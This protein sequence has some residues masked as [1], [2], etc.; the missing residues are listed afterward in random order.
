MTVQPQFKAVGSRFKGG[1]EALLG[2]RALL[3][4]EAQDKE[5]STLHII[6]DAHNSLHNV[7]WVSG[8]I[9]SLAKMG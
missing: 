6:N 3:V 4:R 5:E 2:E 1:A 8:S 7:C 9:F